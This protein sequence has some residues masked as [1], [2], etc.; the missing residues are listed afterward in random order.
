MK[1]VECM[2]DEGLLCPKGEIKSGVT[3]KNQVDPSSGNKGYNKHKWGQRKSR[4]QGDKEKSMGKKLPA[5]KAKQDLFK[6]KCFNCDNNGHFVKD[7]P[8]PP[9]VNEFIS[10]GKLILQ[11]GFMVRIGAHKSKA[12]NLLNFNCKINNKI[13][14]CLLD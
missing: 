11:G 6:V 4:F 7:C 8:K 2:E 1:M 14:G 10:Q 9:Q 13:V 3:H 5:K 12:S